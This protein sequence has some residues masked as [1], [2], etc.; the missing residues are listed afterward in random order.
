MEV[1]KENINFLLEKPVLLFLNISMYSNPSLFLKLNL[2]SEGYLF[3]ILIAF[4]LIKLIVFF[5]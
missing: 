2:N 4:S 3:L 1:L 5:S